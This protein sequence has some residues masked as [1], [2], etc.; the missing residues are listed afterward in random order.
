MLNYRQLIYNNYFSTQV[1]KSSADHLLLLEEQVRHNTDELAHLLPTDKSAKI[2]DLGC[3]FGGMVEVANRLGY[4]NVQG[5]DISAEQIAT[6]HSLGIKN[7]AELS[8]EAFF[9]KNEKVD[10]II[11]LD[12]IEHFTK[13]ELVSFLS[14]AR[15]CLNPRGRVIF[16]TPNMDAA[17]TS[18][19]AYGDISHEV[20]LNK[21]SAKQLLSSCGYKNINIYGGLLKSPNPLKNLIRAAL[22]SLIKLYKK[23]ELFATARTWHNV[24]FEPNL[25]IIAST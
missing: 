5:Y 19:Y 13:D 12:I 6:A 11:G 18:V 15:K 4:I 2:V 21:S 9:K 1:N 23:I 16:R 8:I 10:V 17:Q 14:D 25:L 3:G 20:F 24:V 7:V 22:W